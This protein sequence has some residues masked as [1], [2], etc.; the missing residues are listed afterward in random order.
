MSLIGFLFLLATTSSTHGDPKLN[1][2]S[3]HTMC[4]T[5]FFESTANIRKC[6]RHT[7]VTLWG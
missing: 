2:A 4:E 5:K 7:P 3:L 1:R 6:K